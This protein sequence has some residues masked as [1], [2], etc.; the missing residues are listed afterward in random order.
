MR[1]DCDVV[2]FADDIDG[3]ID[4]MHNDIDLRIFDQEVGDDIGHGELH[5]RDATRASYRA[6]RLAEPVTDR[7]LSQFCFAEHRNRVPVEVFPCIGH[8]EATRG[9]VEQPDTEVALELLDTVTQGRFGVRNVRLAAVKPPRSTTC[10]N[11]KK[12][13]KSSMGHPSSNHSDVEF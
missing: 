4:G 1:S 5:G 13:F 2:V 3:A 12:S 11:K 9:P 6:A 8:S 7:G 10:T